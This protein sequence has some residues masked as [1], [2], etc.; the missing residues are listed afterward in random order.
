M[1][2]VAQP[3]AV[4]RFVDEILNYRGNRHWTVPESKRV[5]AR[6]SK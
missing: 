6:L 1:I 5:R 4:G 3:V 2:A